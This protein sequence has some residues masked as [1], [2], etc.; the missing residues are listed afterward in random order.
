M[1]IKEKINVCSF[2]QYL[3]ITRIKTQYFSVPLLV[4]GLW[5][6]AVSPG[7]VKNWSLIAFPISFSSHSPFSR[8]KTLSS[9]LGLKLHASSIKERH[10]FLWSLIQV[11]I[12]AFLLDI[13][14]NKRKLSYWMSSRGSPA[15]INFT[16]NLKKFNEVFMC[17]TTSQDKPCKNQL[18]WERE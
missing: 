10:L 3:N 17:I 7:E 13:L 9:Y 5:E 4:G 8:C 6:T 2:Q 18:C 16:Q 15:F 14:E 12:I 1:K 11:G